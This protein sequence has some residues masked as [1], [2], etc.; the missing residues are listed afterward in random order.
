MKR[1]IFLLLISSVGLKACSSSHNSDS[2]V[3]FVAYWQLGDK[4]LYEYRNQDMAIISND[5]I[6]TEPTYIERFSLEIITATTDEYAIKYTLQDCKQVVSNNGVEEEIDALWGLPKGTTAIFHTN[7][8]GE[9][10]EIVNWNIP[11]SEKK[12]LPR[13]TVLINI[14][15]PGNG[16]TVINEEPIEVN[17]NPSSKISHVIELFNYYGIALKRDSIYSWE[18]KMPS[19]WNDELI[20][21]KCEICAFQDKEDKDIIYIVN[22]NKPDSKQL[23]KN[24][25]AHFSQLDINPMLLKQLSNLS[26]EENRYMCFH[27]P[28][29]WVVGFSYEKRSTVDRDITLSIK[30]ISVL[31]DDETDF[32]QK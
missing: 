20:D 30:E 18:D 6:Y 17:E 5:T 32:Y 21:A 31:F 24:H 12:N 19:N 25:R 8:T 28:S 16:L 7:G 29:G 11:K 1:L 4:A 15:S 3:H 9:L 23:I 27:Q 14:N 22:I 13:E 10:K 26:V 2:T